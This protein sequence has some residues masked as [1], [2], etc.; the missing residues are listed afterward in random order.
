MA[1][2]D[3]ATATLERHL[4][5]L[6][7]NRISGA[8]DLAL[9]ALDLAG[10]WLANGRP[11][12]ELAA[13]LRKMHPA[14]APVTNVARLL[15]EPVSD[16]PSRLRDVEASLRDGNRRIARNLQA[17]IPVGSTVLTLSNSSTVRGALFVLDPACV[18]VMRSLPGGEGE[19]QAEALSTGFAD[20]GGS[21]LVEV[22]PDM[23]MANIV[24]LVD[25]A[26]VGIDSYDRGG[27]ILHKVGTLP[28]AL[29][30]RHFE[31]P[32]YAAG[33]SLKL[34]ARPLQAAPERDAAAREQ[35]FDCTPG[36]LI[37]RIVTENDEGA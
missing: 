15:E 22:V 37:T 21:A 19:A 34:V 23:A 28:L 8:L 5:A 35:L 13:E 3:R 20:R 14:I 32:L 26:L 1:D 4:E 25:C 36:T 16:L 12:S 27:A 11:P 31:K 6:R 9:Q 7:R 24:P 2:R 18:F 29:C 33:H 30:C 10:H 17:V